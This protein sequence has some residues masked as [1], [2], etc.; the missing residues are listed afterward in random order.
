MAENFA[1][2]ARTVE[3]RGAVEMSLAEDRGLFNPLAMQGSDPGKAIEITDR[4]SRLKMQEITQRNGKTVNT[5]PDVER[6]WVKKPKR[7]GVAPLLD[8]DDEMATKVGLGMPLSEGVADAA[9]AYHDDQWLVGF[10]GTA[11]TGEEGATQTP[12]KSANIIASDVETSTVHTGL[13][14]FKIIRLR[15]LWR[16][17]LNKRKDPIFMAI[18]SEE[19]ED[20]L[21]I[22]KYQNGDYRNTKALEDGEITPFLGIN[23]V[24]AEIQNAG[25]YP[26]GAAL[27]VDSGTGYR[28]LPV[29]TPSGMHFH[30]WLQFAAYNDIRADL[31]HSEQ[32]AGYAC[33]MAARLNED[34]CFQV[35]CA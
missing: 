22:D 25:E 16:A 12:F 28:K 14:L 10:Y 32:F 26:K 19:I 17:R 5:E 8:P 7:S 31:H 1:E 35:I 20:L 34:K 27:A 18:T 9:R 11:W 30:T 21:S 3:F 2:V 33:S 13:T 6:R 29:W 15:K 23:F 24:P 4:F